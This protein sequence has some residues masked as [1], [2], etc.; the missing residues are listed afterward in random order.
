LKTTASLRD[1]MVIGD[2]G[3]VYEAQGI[4]RAWPVLIGIPER[5]EHGSGAFASK[6]LPR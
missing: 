1:Q 5:S 4:A 3:V 6:T 2:P